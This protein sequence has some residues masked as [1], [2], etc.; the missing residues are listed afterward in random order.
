M[1]GILALARLGVAVISDIVRSPVMPR[2]FV[3]YTAGYSGNG[4]AGGDTCGCGMRIAP[5]KVVRP[6][7]KT[8]ALVVLICRPICGV[9]ALR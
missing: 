1:A 6:V 7:A 9:M 4:Q 2:A 5:K 8:L 3:A